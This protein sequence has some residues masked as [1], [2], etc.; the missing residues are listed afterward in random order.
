MKAIMDDNVVLYM[1]DN[2]MEF[3]DRGNVNLPLLIEQLEETEKAIKNMLDAIQQGI[4]TSSTKQRL[5]ELE[6]VK[7]DLEVSILQKEIQ[8]PKLTREQVTVWICRFRETDATMQD[9]RQRLI[10]SFVN[11]IYLYEDKMFI[12]FNYKDGQK[13]ITFVDIKGSDLI[14]H[15][16]HIPLKPGFEFEGD[17]S[18]CLQ[19]VVDGKSYIAIHN[20]KSLIG[21]CFLYISVRLF[22]R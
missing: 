22:R 15:R 20:S 3:Q 16:H 21:L 10:D 9:Q 18:L 14:T 2:V 19:G 5:E 4:L 7:S 1:V 8:K 6:Q 13:T 11:S 12:S 17:F